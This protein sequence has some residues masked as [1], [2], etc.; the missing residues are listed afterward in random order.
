MGILVVP[1]YV[2][3][4]GLRPDGFCPH[5]WA[6]R[7]GFEDSGF[8]YPP[9]PNRVSCDDVTRG[10]FQ[11]F[12]VRRGDDMQVALVVEMGGSCGRSM[13]SMLGPSDRGSCR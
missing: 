5:G 3:R 11:R 9:L 10:R 12:L 7:P 2:A 13:A 6:L 8:G 1:P 4:E